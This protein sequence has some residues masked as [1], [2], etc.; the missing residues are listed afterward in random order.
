[1]DQL[2]NGTCHFRQALLSCAEVELNCSLSQL[3][4]IMASPALRVILARIGLEDP[5]AQA[6]LAEDGFEVWAQGFKDFAAMAP[7]GAIDLSPVRR[8][9][10]L[11]FAVVQSRGGEFH[12]KQSLQL[13]S[14][15]GRFGVLTSRNPFMSATPSASTPST[16]TAA[17]STITSLRLSTSPQVVSLVAHEASLQWRWF[18]KASP[19]DPS[20]TEHSGAAAPCHHGP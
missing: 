3:C 9:M 19:S 14:T 4:F 7:G 13:Q 20:F 16:S 11:F 12:V 8:D 15:T 17:S 1:M 6:A 5:D 18:G 2:R 10:E